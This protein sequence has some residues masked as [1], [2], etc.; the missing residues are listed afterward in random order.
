MAGV[1]RLDDGHPLGAG[2]AV[3]A[4]E[5]E[6][7]QPAA[8][9]KTILAVV[10]RH[11]GV[12]LAGVVAAERLQHAQGVALRRSPGELRVNPFDGRDAGGAQLAA[13][14]LAAAV[15]DPDAESEAARVDVGPRNPAVALTRVKGGQGAQAGGEAWLRRAPGPVGA[16]WRIGL[17]VKPRAGAGRGG[18]HGPRLPRRDWQ[19]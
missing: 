8:E 10:G 7:T 12:A 18:G 2:A 16:E 4:A 15:V 13:T 6:V 3:G 14:A 11:P 1:D 5:T 19:A 9:T 17:T